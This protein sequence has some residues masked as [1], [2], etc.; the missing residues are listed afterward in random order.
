MPSKLSELPQANQEEAKVFA[1]MAVAF[2]KEHGLP[3]PTTYK[4]TQGSESYRITIE[5]VH[6]NG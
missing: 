3:F 1:S 5:R 6:D 4:I 2:V